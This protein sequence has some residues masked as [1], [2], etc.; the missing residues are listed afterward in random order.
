MEECARICRECAES[1]RQMAG[2]Y[3]NQGTGAQQ[4]VPADDL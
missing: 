1:C 4:R 2:S 3:A